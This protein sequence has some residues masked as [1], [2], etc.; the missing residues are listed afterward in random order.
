M[1]RADS[2][3]SHPLAN[4][5]STITVTIMVDSETGQPSS[6]TM[7]HNNVP[8]SDLVYIATLM[9]PIIFLRNDPISLVKLTE[10]IE[11]EHPAFLGKFDPLRKSFDTWLKTPIVERRTLGDVPAELRSETPQMMVM[12][13]RP[14]DRLPNGIELNDSTS[15]MHFALVYFYG[16]AWHSDDDKA[17]EY[18]AASDHDKSFIA[19]CA[20]LRTMHAIRFIR[21]LHTWVNEVRSMGMDM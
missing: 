15:D 13:S 19:K 12:Q 18:A 6:A 8:V 2:I 16:E 3:L 17:A 1:R 11:R 5:E 4:R 20:E 21:S 10:R 7:D 9:R 14:V